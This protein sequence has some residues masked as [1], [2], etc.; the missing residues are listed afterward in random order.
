MSFPISIQTDVV[1]QVVF[2]LHIPTPDVG[3]FVTD[4][5]MLALVKSA[6]N[7]LSGLLTRSFGDGYFAE[8]MTFQ[9]QAGVDVISLPPNFETLRSLH[10]IHNDKAYELERAEP[11]DYSIEATNWLSHLPRYTVEA[12][13]IRLTPPPDNEYTLRIGYSSALSVSAL[14]DTI[15]GQLSWAEWLVADICCKIRQREQRPYDEFMQDK[16]LIEDAIKSQA[17]QRD[18]SGSVQVRDARGALGRDHVWGRGR[19]R[20]YY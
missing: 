5:H 11:E 16:L 2:R 20:I 19:R 8:D 14:T 13:V 18:R 15:Y 1:D 17:A 12:N 6:V 10:L 7:R 3:E 4:T 9:T